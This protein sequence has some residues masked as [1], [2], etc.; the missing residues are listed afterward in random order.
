MDSESNN[1]KPKVS[2]CQRIDV[3]EHKKEENL[4][5]YKG[6]GNKYILFLFNAFYLL[7]YKESNRLT[8]L[9]EGTISLNHLI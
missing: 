7:F 3:Y 2:K 6:K 9:D 5:K 4:D 8:D 1:T